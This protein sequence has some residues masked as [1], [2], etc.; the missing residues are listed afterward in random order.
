MH[1]IEPHFQWRD[2]YQAEKDQY[3]PFYGR[4]YSEFHFTNKV[5][6]Y[7]LHPQWDEFGSETLYVKVIFADYEAGY[8]IMELI[9]EW[10][11]A[12]HNDVALLKREVIDLMLQAGINKYIISMENVLNFHG[13]DDSYY[14]EWKEEVR[15]EGG[16]VAFLNVLP[17]VAEELQDMNIDH[18]LS[19]GG[20]L[21]GVN[22][23]P[24]K[25]VRVFEAIESVLAR[26]RLA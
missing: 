26:H 16:W 22:W 9:G 17:H 24:Q 19:F 2:R 13:S 15:D 11:D 20:P 23:R 5:Y 14:E 12:L 7:L 6:N 8:A 25:P 1:T 10:N 18:Y 21:D 4:E 3:S